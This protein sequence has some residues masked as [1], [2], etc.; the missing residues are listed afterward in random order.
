MLL[1]QL[2]RS[3]LADVV[4]VLDAE[5]EAPGLNAALALMFGELAAMISDLAAETPDEG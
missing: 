2:D 1:S 4:S 3:S 5:A